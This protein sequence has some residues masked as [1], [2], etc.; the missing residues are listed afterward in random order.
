M[1]AARSG[2]DEGAGQTW[3]SPLPAPQTLRPWVSSRSAKWDNNARCFTESFWGLHERIQVQNFSTSEGL[4]E[5]IWVV[6]FCFSPKVE[7]V[8]NSREFSMNSELSVPLRLT[9]RSGA[10]FPLFLLRA[11]K[12]LLILFRCFT[13]ATRCFSEE[14]Q[15]ACNHT[16]LQRALLPHISATENMKGK[17][18]L[19]EIILYLSIGNLSW[20]GLKWLEKQATFTV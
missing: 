7:F 3:R 19:T 5:E 10:G 1:W 12:C 4:K 18:N 15:M 14:Q 2:D 13:L 20:E 6:L 16:R 8:S 11:N 9:N 17:D